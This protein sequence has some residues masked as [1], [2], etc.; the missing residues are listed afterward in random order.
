MDVKPSW[1][2]GYSSKHWSKP[3]ENRYKERKSLVQTQ[4]F[5]MDSSQNK[6]LKS[7][8]ETWVMNGPSP[9]QV[10]SKS[11]WVKS[12]HFELE[13]LVK[14]SHFIFFS[15]QVKSDMRLKSTQV[16]VSDLTCYNTA[17]KTS[18]GPPRVPPTERSGYF[19]SLRV[20]LQVTLWRKFTNNDL[21]LKVWG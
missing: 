18:H 3:S 14:S 17:N 4:V 8:H 21:N 19:H 11:V 15:S 6:R 10:E 1:C 9:S 12:S 13:P 16:Q 7:L 5:P 2:L 20:H